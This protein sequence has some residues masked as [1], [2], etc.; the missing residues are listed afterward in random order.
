MVKEKEENGDEM[1]EERLVRES[2]ENGDEMS[3][4]EVGKR[5]KNLEQER[6]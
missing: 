2:E 5:A 6:L 3:R 1:I 4:R